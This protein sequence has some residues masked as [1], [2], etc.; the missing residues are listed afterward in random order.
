MLMDI[1]IIN[2][3]LEIKYYKNILQSLDKIDVDE[4][5]LNSH[6]KNLY[7]QLPSESKLSETVTEKKKEINSSSETENH[8]QIFADDDLY[9]KTTTNI[10][11]NMITLTTN[12]K[13]FYDNKIV[14]E[15]NYINI[16]YIKNQDTFIHSTITQNIEIITKTIDDLLN[17]YN[18]TCLTNYSLDF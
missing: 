5:W 2:S 1:E 11:N 4:P 12:Y 18:N 17:S 16:Q 7:D 6:L 13:E 3:K 9:K 15:V 8:K 10:N 14:D